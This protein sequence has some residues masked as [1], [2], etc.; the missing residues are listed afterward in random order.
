MLRSAHLVLVVCS[1][2]CLAQAA[3]PVAPAPA[4][5]QQP[6]TTTPP[7][8]TTTTTTTTGSGAA[9][10]AQ[11]NAA[12]Q[13]IERLR[14]CQVLYGKKTII[15][16]Q[17]TD[18]STPSPKTPTPPASANSSP[19]K[20]PDD[21]AIV[22]M[23]YCLNNVLGN[24]SYTELQTVNLGNDPIVGNIGVQFI[25][26]TIAQQPKL[27]LEIR[28]QLVA[29]LITQDYALPDFHTTRYR[30]IGGVSVAAASSATPQAQF[31]GD[32][33][34]QFPLNRFQ[35]LNSLLWL[36]GDLRVGSIAQ[37]GALS[38]LDLSSGLS[39][40]VTP[41]SASPSQIVQSIELQS[42]FD[43]RL[44]SLGR[45]QTP[46]TVSAIV[47]GGI[48][49]PI[50]ASQFNPVFYQ[51][52]TTV[53]SSLE[54]QYPNQNLSSQFAAACNTTT[55]GTST[56]RTCYVAFPPMD[57]TTLYHD[58]GAGVRLKWYWYDATSRAYM[59]PSI[60]DLTIGQNEYVTGGSFH[61]SVIHLGGSSPIPDYPFVFIFG[62]F[63]TRM[64]GKSS[65][66][67]PVLLALAPSG[68][69]INLTDPTVVPVLVPQPDRDRWQIGIGLDLKT[70]ISHW[71]GSKASNTSTTTSTTTTTTPPTSP[72][73]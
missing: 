13:T 53:Q 52:T 54:Q 38:T 6:A 45:N 23:T 51:A 5:Q 61:G 65:S 21:S 7:S 47:A 15:S 69:T 8:T 49:T 44:K 59:F 9:T 14:Q 26:N 2:I 71:T 40:Y 41:S 39:T 58:Y 27:T 46:T 1:G 36:W 19:P 29:K 35:D 11:I 31:L 32:A 68:T 33:S 20:K 3:A 18:A 55:N 24:D 73:K 17:T 56:P 25:L 12:V 67:S 48:I 30:I 70:I 37:P 60:F 34:V 42:G 28:D 57:R 43:I 63:D 22:G 10:T 72:S 50:S 64:T 4:P 62:S 66:G 16:P